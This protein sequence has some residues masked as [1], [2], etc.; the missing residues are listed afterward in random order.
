MTVRM[1]LTWLAL[2]G[3]VAASAQRAGEWPQ[4]LGPSRDGA[5]APFTMPAA[6]K[7][8]EAWRSPLPSGGAGIAV[9]GGRAFT[10]GSDGERDYLFA[11]EAA[12]GKEV[13]RAALGSTHADAA[14]GPGSTPA[15]A[16]DLVMAVGSS[17]GVHAFTRADGRPIWQKDLAAS[18]KSRFAAR[19]GCSMSP[20]VAGD[21]VVLPTGAAAEPDR[22]VALRAAS[23]E[24]AWSAKVERSTNAS[25]GLRDAPGV[26]QVVYHHV[27]P[28]SLSGVAG[29]NL[30]DG[31]VA[32]SADAP[33]GVSANAPLPLSGGRVLLQTWQGSTMFEIP[34]GPAP[35]PKALWTITAI[36][37][38][39]SP[40]VAHGGH[41]FGFGGNSGEYLTCVDA[42]TG[43]VTWT[44]RIY[45]GSTSLVDRTIVVLSE[46]AGLL[47]LVAA[48]PAA[49]RETARLTVL[50]PG[51]KTHTPPSIAGGRIFLR[52]LDE[53]VAVDIR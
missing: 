40:P 20:L 10:L 41:L 17:C 13:W 14:D 16:G 8:V 37:A 51:A 27:K 47:R 4:Y 39:N 22:L 11:L 33:G 46:S 5:A 38:D 24:Q 3:A 42:A 53:L 44:S 28:P 6:P 32:W 15:I 25:P 48:D 31:A 29:V 26:H 30:A 36:S 50:R 21:L 2:L 34:G 52:N 18:Y 7:L 12:S 9:G 43:Q 23:G 49:Y 19:G 35:V 1:A 45:R